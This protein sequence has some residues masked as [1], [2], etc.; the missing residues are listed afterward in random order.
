M[1]YIV[2]L[3]SNEC[4]ILQGSMAIRGKAPVT[5]EHITT[6]YS[7]WNGCHYQTVGGTTCIDYTVLRCLLVPAY[8]QAS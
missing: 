7:H 8:L 4:S 5:K 1:E 2:L 3:S 6:F